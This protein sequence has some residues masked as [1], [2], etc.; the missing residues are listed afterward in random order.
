M[1]IKH[2]IGSLLV[3]AGIF[4]A[5]ITVATETQTGPN[6]ISEKILSNKLTDEVVVGYCWF[7]LDGYGWIYLC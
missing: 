3:A 2:T 4:S 7:F 6:I 1:N 5:G